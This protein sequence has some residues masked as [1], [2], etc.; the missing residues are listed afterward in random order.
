MSSQTP[1]RLPVA[2]VSQTPQLDERRV[3]VMSLQAL[4][5]PAMM[6]VIEGVYDTLPGRTS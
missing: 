5:D 2:R 3:L 4:L 6:Q 1:G